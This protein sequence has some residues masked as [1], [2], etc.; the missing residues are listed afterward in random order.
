MIGSLRFIIAWGSNAGD[1]WTATDTVLG[2]ALAFTDHGG[3]RVNS[4][5][6]MFKIVVFN[7]GAEPVT[8]GQLQTFA[9]V[10]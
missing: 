7:D 6:A 3:F 5:G 10:R 9:A 2:S 8:I 1:M 4:Y